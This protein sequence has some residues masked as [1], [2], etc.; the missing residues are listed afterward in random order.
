MY[1]RSDKEIRQAILALEIEQMNEAIE[2]AKAVGNIE[3]IPRLPEST[4][5]R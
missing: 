1:P 5:T 2:K 3:N 4:G